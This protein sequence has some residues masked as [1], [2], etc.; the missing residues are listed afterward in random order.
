MLE[1]IKVLSE[2]PV[3]WLLD[4][5]NPSI[6]YFT[7]RNVLGKKENDLDVVEAKHAIPN[8]RVVQKILGKQNPVGF[9]EERYSPYYPKYKSFLLA[10]NGSRAVGNG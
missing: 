2:S 9:W 8:S 3:D 7:M 6:R 5:S 10:D 4:E 1:W